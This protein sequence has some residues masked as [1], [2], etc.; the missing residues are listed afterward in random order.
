[1]KKVKPF[2]RKNYRRVV[3]SPNPIA[4]I[5]KDLIKKLHEDNVI[6]I[7]AGGGGIPVID[8]DGNLKG[9]E[10]V[11]DKDLAGEKLAEVVGAKI[12]LI[13]TDVEKVKLN[14]GKPE[15]QDIKRMSLSEAKKYLQEGHFLPRSMEPKISACIRFLETG[16]KKAIITSIEKGLEALEGKTGTLIT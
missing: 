10:A 12:F 11:I 2:G 14:Y 7:A 9:V 1:M 5:E 6:I 3:P 8:C 13:L 4:L 15:Q 16:G